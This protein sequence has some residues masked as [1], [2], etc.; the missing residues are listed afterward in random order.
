MKFNLDLDNINYIKIIYKNADD[1]T[2]CT[3]AA[4][5]RIGEREIFACAKFEDGL[6]IKTPQ[7]VFLSFVCVNGLYRTSTTLKFIESEPPYIFFTLK[8]PEGLEYQQN[9]EYFRIKIEENAI[10]S[11]GNKVLPCK[12]Y[13]ISASGVRLTIPEHLEEVDDVTI[14]LLFDP[15]NVRANAKFIREDNEDGILKAAFKFIDLP[16]SSIDIISQKCIQKQLEYKRHNV[17]FS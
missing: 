14:D 4:I 11:Y 17:N 7:E 2:A 16:E 3:K 5:K 13:D 9:R 8:T 10:L 12:T 6:N 1:T 15:K